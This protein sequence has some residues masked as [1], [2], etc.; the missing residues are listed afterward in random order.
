[1]IDQ[2]QFP[3][4][5][6]VR[7]KHPLHPDPCPEQGTVTA[8]IEQGPSW[9]SQWDVMVDNS[10]SMPPY[11]LE[12]ME[13]IVPNKKDHLPECVEVDQQTYG[14]WWCICDRLRKAERRGESNAKYKLRNVGPDNFDLGWHAGY[15]S[16]HKAGLGA[17]E[18]LEGKL[19][20]FKNTLAYIQKQMEE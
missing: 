7:C 18:N 17:I 3:I 19:K 1:M 12:K 16:G 14:T 20:N 5:T 13:E 4:G 8:W 2:S 11:F 6:K 15:K 10:W 9:A